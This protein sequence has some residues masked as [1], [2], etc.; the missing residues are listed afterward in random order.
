MVGS[1]DGNLRSF[2]FTR[3]NGFNDFFYGPNQSGAWVFSHRW[4]SEVLSLS[5]IRCFDFFLPDTSSLPACSL[6]TAR[7][8]VVAPEARRSHAFSSANAVLRD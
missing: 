8:A 1:V 2:R 6:R 4:S 3:N 7:A 5:A